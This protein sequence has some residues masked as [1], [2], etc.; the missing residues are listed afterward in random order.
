[1]RY[2]QLSAAGAGVTGGGVKKGRTFSEYLLNLENKPNELSLNYETLLTIL[3]ELLLTHF[4]IHIIICFQN[5][6]VYSNTTPSLR[7]GSS[8]EYCTAV[9]SVCL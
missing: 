8:D 7:V 9:P 2:N 3:R 5:N 6:K 4:F 1:M